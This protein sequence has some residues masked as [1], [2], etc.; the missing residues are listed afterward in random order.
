MKKLSPLAA[1]AAAVS[2]VFNSE[3]RRGLRWGHGSEHDSIV[4]ASASSAARRPQT[5]HVF[6]TDKTS[7]RGQ[8]HG[9][10]ERGLD[11]GESYAGLLPIDAAASDDEMQELYF[12]FFPKEKPSDDKEIVIW[13]TGGPGCSS[14]GELLQENGPISWKHGTRAPVRN[15]WSWHR[16]ANVVWVDQP[17]GT[18]YSRGPVPATDQHDVARQFL[19]FWRN[20][21]DA[22]DLHGYEVYVAGSSYSGLFT[23]YTSSAMLDAAAASGRN[24]DGDYFDV[25]GMMVLDPL[26]SQYG[27]G[28]D[29]AVSRVLDY[30]GPAFSLNETAR[31]AVREIENRCGYRDY[32]GRYLVFPASGVQPVRIPGS[33][34]YGD[35]VPECDALAVV[36][37]AERAANPCFSVFNVLRTCPLPFDPLGFSEVTGYYPASEPVYFDRPDVKEAIHAPPGRAW[38]FCSRQPVFVG[39]VD[40]SQTPGPGSLPVIPGVV[41]RTGNVIVGHGLRDLIVQSAGTL[42]AIQNMTWGGALG[43]RPRPE[44]TLRVPYHCDGDA[45]W[46]APAGGGELGL[47][48]FETPTA[49]HFLGRLA[50]SFSFRALEVL[51]GKVG[52]F[53]SDPPLTMDAKERV[54]LSEEL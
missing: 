26:L 42:M 22:F 19:G 37:E 8:W 23:P 25:G 41:E 33:F 24:S 53:G 21:V 51:L 6:L 36:I 54:A 45:G 20:F 50:P 46:G 28:Q 13:L 43:F 3:D 32:V 31:E 35:Y 52:D 29:F 12:W 27:L 48:Y 9:H 16:P 14:I 30:W 39:D 34:R 15:P 10:P 1:W 2:A 18:G 44:A 49:G 17:V 38:R 7:I 40:G 47:T 11:A 4:G 5:K